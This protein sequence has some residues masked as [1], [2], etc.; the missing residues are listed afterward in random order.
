MKYLVILDQAT[1]LLP[2][3]I[4]LRRTSI[5]QKIDSRWS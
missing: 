5:K 4:F 2:N 1:G 3:P